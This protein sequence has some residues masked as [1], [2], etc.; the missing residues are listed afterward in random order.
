VGDSWTN[1]D[2]GVV[3]EYINDGDSS[4]WVSFVGS[5]VAANI[6]TTS[7]ST[8]VPWTYSYTVTGTTTGNTETEIFIGGVSGSRVPVATNT[9]VYYT[10]DLVCRRTDVPGDYAAYYVKGVATNVS[11]TVT[12]V[13]SLYELIIVR[14]DSNLL[15][16]FRA[17]DTNNSVG[18]YVTGSPG[19]TFNW[20]CSLITTEV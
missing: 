15:V 4:Q 18:I 9:T 14:T 19:K 10:G 8:S 16:D 11:G 17:D 2:T 7:T 3:Y 13:G 1:S 5:G 12:D 20:K 6:S